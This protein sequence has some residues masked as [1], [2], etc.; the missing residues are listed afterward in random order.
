MR[1]NKTQTN[2][3]KVIRSRYY[4]QNRQQLIHIDSLR[5]N[6]LLHY[7]A[8]EARDA[9]AITEERGGERYEDRTG[10]RLVRDRQR[11]E[12][13]KKFMIHEH[14]FFVKILCKGSPFVLVGV[15][16]SLWAVRQT[17][18]VLLVVV[19]DLYLQEPE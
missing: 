4:Q 15:L 11:E 10:K 9:W 6:Q 16:N 3:F 8:A 12:V 5:L 18:A 13:E 17:A 1:E 2:Y 7:V 14:T 19:H